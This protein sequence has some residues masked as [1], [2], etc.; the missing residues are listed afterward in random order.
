MM[1]DVVIIGG[2]LSGLA[3]A[4]ELEHMGLDYTLIEVKPR[5]GGSISSTTQTGFIV[6]DGPMLALDT[7]LAPV[8][9]DLALH[10][11]IFEARQDEDGTWVA[12]KQGMGTLIDTLAA[13][14]AKEGAHG[15]TMMRM[16]VSSLGQIASSQDSAHFMICMEN[17]MVLDAGALIVAAP[18]RYTERMFHTLRPEISYRLLDTR[19]DHIARLSLGYHKRDVGALPF[20]PPPNYPITYLHSLDYSERVPDDHV[21]IQMGIRYVPDKG[22]APDIVGETAALLGWPLNPVFE[23]ISIWPESD[24]IQWLDDSHAENLDIIRHLLPDGVFLIGSDYTPGRPTLAERIT[25]GRDAARR[26]ASFIY[27]I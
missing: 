24:P 4:F 8:L 23:H 11:A 19:Y 26:A 21:L 13:P 7:K 10:E 16:A 1:R 2:G 12:F 18:A 20:D 25:Q 6:D 5:L 17:G 15:T 9:I 27:P 22:L 3:A 14:L